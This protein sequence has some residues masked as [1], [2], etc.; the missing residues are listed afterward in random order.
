VRALQ[1]YLSL[2]C[3]EGAADRKAAGR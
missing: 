2:L 3:G 1:D